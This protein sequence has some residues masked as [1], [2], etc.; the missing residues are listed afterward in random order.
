MAPPSKEDL[1]FQRKMDE[2]ARATSQLIVPNGKKGLELLQ[3]AYRDMA[4]RKEKDA[5]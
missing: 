3:Q 1:E 5:A 2:F 4:A